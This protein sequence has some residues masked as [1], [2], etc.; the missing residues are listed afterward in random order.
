LENDHNNEDNTQQSVWRRENDIRSE[1]EKSKLD[2][3]DVMSKLADVEKKYEYFKQQVTAAED[4]EMQVLHDLEKAAIQIMNKE[5]TV[6]SDEGESTSSIE[7]LVKI[8]TKG[9]KKKK[10]KTIVVDY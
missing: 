1:L 2:L 7:E 9:K 5:E 6:L 4:K 10:K 8:P 3:T